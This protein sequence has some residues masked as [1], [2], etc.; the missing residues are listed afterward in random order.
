M[1]EIYYAEEL[2]IPSWMTLVRMVSWNFPGLE[3]EAQVLDCEATLRK[4][5]CEIAI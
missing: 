2:D 5:T 1:I 4:N 3:T